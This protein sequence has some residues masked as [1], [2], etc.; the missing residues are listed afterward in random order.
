MSHGVTE[1]GGSVHTEGGERQGGKDEAEEE[2]PICIRCTR[3]EISG[4]GLQC[5][6]STLHS[7]HLGLD[8]KNPSILTQFYW[9][10][11][12]VERIFKG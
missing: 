11:M 3:S 9:F 10:R 2:Q 12:N 6:V 5:R 8:K 4:Q 7:C 1:L